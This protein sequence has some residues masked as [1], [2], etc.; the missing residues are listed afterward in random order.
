MLS[1][2]AKYPPSHNLKFANEI[3]LEFSFVHHQTFHGENLTHPLAL[4]DAEEG[5]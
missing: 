5:I 1:C 3:V 4:L 2:R